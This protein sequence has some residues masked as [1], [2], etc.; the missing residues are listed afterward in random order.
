[1]GAGGLWGQTSGGPSL[2]RGFWAHSDEILGRWPT[3]QV[4][5]QEG[6]WLQKHL[7]EI[8]VAG[9]EAAGRGW[10]GG[11]GASP[12]RESARGA[13]GPGAV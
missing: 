7:G 11:V 4:G 9:T 5:A 3:L 1:M 13:G 8:C 12:V 6:G 2:T 10:G